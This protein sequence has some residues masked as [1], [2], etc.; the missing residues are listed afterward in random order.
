MSLLGSYQKP[1]RERHHNN[2]YPTT[3]SNYGLCPCCDT[4]GHHRETLMEVFRRLT[5][6]SFP[7]SATFEIGIS[8]KGVW[9]QEMVHEVCFCFVKNIHKFSRFGSEKEPLHIHFSIRIR[10]R[11][12]FYGDF[13][14][15]S[16]SRRRRSRTMTSH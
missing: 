10:R 5:S 6:L 14:E 13:V 9:M 8:P 15:S 7:F 3:N 4:R 12:T 16:Y 11:S 2:N 1:S